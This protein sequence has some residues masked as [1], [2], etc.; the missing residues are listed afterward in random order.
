M[1]ASSVGWRDMKKLTANLYTAEKIG[2]SY[3]GGQ[4]TNENGY[5]YSSG[6]YPT[7]ITEKELP[8]W[9]VAG[10]MYNTYGYIS[11]KGVQHLVY[12]PTY[13]NHLYKDDFLFISYEKPIIPTEDE[14]WYE[15]Y[16]ETV[17]GF[18]IPTFLNAVR[19]HSAIDIGAIDKAVK[20]KED[21]YRKTYPTNYRKHIF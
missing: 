9:F 17:S 4:E 14:R 12:K 21:W 10:T 5:L 8:D 2:I 11:A 20:A 6:K 15:G 19:H 16:D 1:S 18:L 3:N 7:R 13:S